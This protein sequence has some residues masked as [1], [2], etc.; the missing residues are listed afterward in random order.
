MKTNLNQLKQEAHADRSKRVHFQT[1]LFLQASAQ[2][3]WFG[4]AAFRAVFGVLF[5]TAFA[6]PASAQDVFGRIS[7][8]VTDTQGAV[9]PD[10]N[11]TITNEQTR[12]SRSL[13]TD[14]HGLYVA[15]H[16]PVGMYTVSASAQQGFKA[17]RKTGN[18]LSAG[19]RLTVDVRLEVGNNTQVIEGTAS[20]EAVNT[21]SGEITRT[22]DAQQVQTAALNQRNYPLFVSL[23]PGAPLTT[24]DQHSLTTGQST[25]A[26]SV[27]GRRTD[28]NNFAVDG[29]F[30][31]DSGSN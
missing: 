17:F 19:A 2:F 14:A 28:G 1:S 30:N 11:I 22:V 26:A 23:L 20:G 4:L 9:I 13:K 27:N 31:M 29:G 3:R 7:G 16:L 12:I 21:V 5:L 15:D 10:A 18:D 8:T 6:E 24:F 25:A